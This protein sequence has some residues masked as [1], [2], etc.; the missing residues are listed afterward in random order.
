MRRTRGWLIELVKWSRSRGSE[1]Y[2]VRVNALAPATSRPTCHSS[3]SRSTDAT[4][5]RTLP[6]SA[7]A[8]VEEL[9]PAIVFLASDAPS[10]I[11]G[12]IL[13]ADGSCPTFQINNT[14]R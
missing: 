14:S 9:A 1:D 12:S 13:V 2:G 6:F 7:T 5:L 10:F 11:T 8:P 4:G 3:T